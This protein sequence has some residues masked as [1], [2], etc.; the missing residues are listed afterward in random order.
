[1]GDKTRLKLLDQGVEVL[2]AQGY[3]GTGIKQV[4]DAVSV[5]KG[6]FYNYFDSKEDFGAEVIKHYS[7]RMLEWMDSI[8]K[9]TD[10]T[11]FSRLKTFYTEAIRS[12]ENNGMRCG[13]LLGNLGAELG[14]RSDVCCVAM[15]EAVAGVRLRLCNVVHEAQR[16]GTVRLDLP[17]EELAEFMFDAWQGALVRMKVEGSARPLQRFCSMVLD[18]LL[19]P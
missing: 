5:P 15:N 7:V 13:C 6:S 10:G 16:E 11:A 17:P 1:M 2:L 12:C 4:L 18:G 9:P 19:R 3:H 14:G 8:L